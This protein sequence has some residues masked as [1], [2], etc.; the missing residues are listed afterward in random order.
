M[1]DTQLCLAIGVPILANATL[2]AVLIAYINARVSGFETSVNQRFDAVNQ[3]F[4]DMRDLW[5]NELR[6]VEEVLDAGLKHLEDERR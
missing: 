6:R 5:R 3:R 4:D 2:I 1:T